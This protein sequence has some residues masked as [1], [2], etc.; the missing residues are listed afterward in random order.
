MNIAARMFSSIDGL[1]EAVPLAE[2]RR[3]LR[4]YRFG[5]ILA[6][7]DFNSKWRT[8]QRQRRSRQR[9]EEGSRALLGA[10]D[11]CPNRD[12]CQFSEAVALAV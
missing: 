9:V 12:N 11:P 5:F 10:S 6:C 8:R 2:Y 1:K 4:K 3:R 7:H